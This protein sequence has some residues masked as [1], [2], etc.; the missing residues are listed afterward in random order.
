[1]LQLP[2]RNERQWSVN[3]L[4][5]CILDNQISIQRYHSIIKVSAAIMGKNG[6]IISLLPFENECQQCV[7]NFRSCI[8]DN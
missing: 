5:L 8:L 2:C 7:N 4:E 3:V 6:V 1:V